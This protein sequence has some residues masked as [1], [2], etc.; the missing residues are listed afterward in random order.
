[1]AHDALYSHLAQLG[2]PAIV[3]SSSQANNPVTMSTSVQFSSSSLITD[4]QRPGMWNLFGSVTPAPSFVG[5]NTQFSVI[6]STALASAPASVTHAQ[7]NVAS[8]TSTDSQSKV[9]SMDFGRV[10]FQ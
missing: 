1:M 8:V 3:G 2:L 4:L 10:L 7:S 6:N 5:T 9:R